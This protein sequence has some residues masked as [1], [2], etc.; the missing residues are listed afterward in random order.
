MTRER[1][2]GVLGRVKRGLGRALADYRMT[3]DGDTLLVALSGGKDSAALLHIM[4][5]RKEWIPIDYNLVPVH[6]SLGENEDRCRIE[7]LN[8]QTAALGLDLKV[9]KSD[10]AFR[11][12][13]QNLPESPCFH[14]SRW[15][16]KL[17]FDY[18]AEKKI[19]KIAFGH[20]RDDI[21]ETA[22]LNLFYGSSFS[23]MRPHQVLF[24]G[25][26][27]II[28]PLA[29]LDEKD[30]ISYCR[31]YALPVNSPPCRFQK[32]TAAGRR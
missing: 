29:Y 28:R 9:L 12:E 10:I 21:L 3:A 1:R 16:R 26:L 15:K 11:L 19:A 20:H 8:E 31:H 22:L 30:V 24:S 14:C 17:L 6:V 7:R 2:K 4:Q 25:R 18:A 13:Q 23:T 5:T 27:T 32:I